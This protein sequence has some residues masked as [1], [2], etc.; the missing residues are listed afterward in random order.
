MSADYHQTVINFNTK[1]G[2]HQTVTFCLNPHMDTKAEIRRKRLG[3]L[4]Q[5]RFGGNQT[6][7][8]EQVGRRQS[9][10]SDMVRGAKSF[11]EKIARDIELKLG[12]PEL[13]LDG[14][15]EQKAQEMVVM[16]PLAD[17]YIVAKS[18]EDL[19]RQLRDRGDDEIMGILQLLVANKDK[20]SGH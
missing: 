2:F 20:F 19:V 12:L 5:D 4:I 8:A 7:F 11:G 14:L 18:P 13:W 17:Y 15:D 10:V 6:E 1:R 16:E 3:Q 9:A